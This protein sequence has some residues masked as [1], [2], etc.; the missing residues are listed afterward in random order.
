MAKP[1]GLTPRVKY[2]VGDVLRVESTAGRIRRVIVTAKDVFEGWAGFIGLYE[3]TQEEVWGFD[4][5]VVSKVR[6]Q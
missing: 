3:D 6:K 2:D 1:G 5:Q 4:L